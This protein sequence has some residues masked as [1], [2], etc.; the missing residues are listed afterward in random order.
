[1]RQ[2]ERSVQGIEVNVMQDLM[3]TN[4]ETF[5][6]VRHWL[7]KDVTVDTDG[8]VVVLKEANISPYIG[9]APLPNYMYVI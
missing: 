8:K 1:M 2:M 9:P 7:A 3:A 5:G 6:Q 4:D